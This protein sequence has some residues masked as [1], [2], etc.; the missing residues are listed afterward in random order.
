MFVPLAEMH[1]LGTDA[2]RALGF[3]A[4]ETS[5]I[6]DHLMDCELR[7]LSYAGLA[8]ILSIA[9]RFARSPMTDERMRVVRETPVSAQLDGAD[10]LGYL[11]GHRATEI[12]VHKATASGLAVVAANRTWYTGMLSYYAEMITGAGMVAMLASNATPW[13]APYGGTEARFGTNPICFGFPSDGI[14]VIWDIGISEIIHAQ[15]VL[16]GRT[17]RRLPPGV[18]YNE[19]GEPTEDPTSALSG[20]FVAWGGHRGSGLGIAVQLLG[21]LAG[22]P[23]LPPQLAEFGMLVLA[24]KPDLFGDPGEFEGRVAEYASAIRATRR[25]DPEVAVRMPFERSA[26][27]RARRI[28]AGGMD[29]EPAVLD[30][31]RLLADGGSPRG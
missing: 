5:I 25:A 11:V 13:V 27:V 30:A 28:E 17:G 29:V 2:L 1:R 16:A 7:G 22:S 10:R 4:D 31:V 26:A 6:V 19:A 24:L 9:D 23:A 20:A 3:D 14:P 8:R 15:A 18:A 21:V 12:A